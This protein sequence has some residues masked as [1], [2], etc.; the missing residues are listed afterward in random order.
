MKQRVFRAAAERARGGL[1][2]L[3]VVLLLVACADPMQAQ[4]PPPN[5]LPTP[6]G[7]LPSLGGP[8]LSACQLVTD[9]EIAAIIGRPVRQTFTED[10]LWD[11][12]CTYTTTSGAPEL[13]V[14]VA[15]TI[16]Q[17]DGMALYERRREYF[18]GA[19]PLAGVGDAASERESAILF[20]TGDILALVNISDRG[21]LD[22]VWRDW[23]QAIVAIVVERLRAVAAPSGP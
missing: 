5:D 13:Q 4:L 21:R 23:N 3:L 1:V 10:E 19:T 22:S 12:E 9:G 14:V 11:S 20:L 18:A 6:I 2:W 17:E 15:I 8:A 16:A 7:K